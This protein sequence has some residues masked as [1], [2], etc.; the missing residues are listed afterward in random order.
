MKAKLKII[1]GA[2]EDETEDDFLAQT[3]RFIQKKFADTL[4]DLPDNL[5]TGD[6]LNVADYAG[7]LPLT[8]DEADQFT[9]WAVISKI[10]NIIGRG[11]NKEVEVELCDEE[12]L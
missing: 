12:P 1:F 2:E 11:D 4:F 7:D 3:D 5:K 6:Q 9:N 8:D 10:N